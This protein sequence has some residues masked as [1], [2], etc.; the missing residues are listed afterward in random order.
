M[1]STRQLDALAFIATFTDRNGYAPTVR[2]IQA[3]LGHKSPSSTYY[4]LSQLRRLRLVSW[5]PE[6]AR[7]LRVLP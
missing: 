4:L 7:T 6:S 2:E 1:L 3:H 5:T